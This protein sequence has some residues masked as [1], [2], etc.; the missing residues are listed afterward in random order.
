MMSSMN[1]FLIPL[2]TACGVISAQATV[3][4]Y[5]VALDST[6]EAAASPGTGSGSVKYDD[7]AHT[8]AL[9]A[10]FVGLNGGVTASHIHAATAVP[11]TGNAGVATPTPTFPGFP[12][13]VTSGSYSKLLDLTAASSWNAA[14]ITGH[15]G[16]AAGAEAAL[17]DA[18]AS[19]KAYWN[20]HS[21]TAPGGESR[22][23]LMV[24]PEPGTLALAGL[25]VCGLVLRA[26]SRKA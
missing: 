3:F 4:E 16:T 1:K 7:V 11:L 12:S 25:G 24:V 19:G 21:S 23:F 6:G 18:M 5:S 20:I 22:G 15:G 14:Y 8:L 2:I 17:A 13:G 26:R 10:T 9:E